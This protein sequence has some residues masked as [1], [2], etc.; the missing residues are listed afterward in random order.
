MT[1]LQITI[2]NLKDVIASGN[3]LLSRLETAQKN[4]DKP[5]TPE[6]PARFI[7]VQDENTPEVDFIIGLE[8]IGG[9]GITSWHELPPGFKGRAYFSRDELRQIIT[10]LQT[11]LGDSNAY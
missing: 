7:V 9:T 1:T 6:F 4:L 11:L 10:G 3:R 8:D 5:K 2:N